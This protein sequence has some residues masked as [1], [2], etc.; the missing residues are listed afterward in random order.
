MVQNINANDVG[1]LVEKKIMI[2]ISGI[3]KLKYLV[4]LVELLLLLLLLRRKYHM[5]VIYWKSRY[6]KISN[7]EKKYFNASDYN[8]FTNDIL[9]T[10]IKNKKLVNE[11]NISGVIK[12][13]DLDKKK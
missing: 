3:F 1:G 7:I 9:H 8:R 12:N 4:L 6:A 11:S 13:T 2:L 5:L 10:K